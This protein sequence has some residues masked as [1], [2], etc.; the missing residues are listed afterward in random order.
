MVQTEN[1][2]ESQDPV[3]LGRISAVFGVQGWVKIFSYTEPREA[4][5]D[6]QELLVEKE[7]KWQSLRLAKGQRHGKTVIGQ[8]EG[9]DDRD[10]AAAFVGADIAVRRENMPDPGKGHYYWSDLTGLTVE[11]SDG[12]ELG[13]VA[14]LLATGANDV[15]VVKGE[16]EILIP[17][18]LDD[19][20]LDVDFA[21]GVISVDWVWD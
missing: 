3:I 12:A 11:N 20:I 15:L 21:T 8:I 17:F 4:I 9:V 16:R 19:V 18:I 7:G 14:Y 10:A 5:L 6:Y 13:K 2:R 1:G